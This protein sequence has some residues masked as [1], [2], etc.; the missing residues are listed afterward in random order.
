MLASNT[1][2]AAYYTV[3][4]EKPLNPR[5][6]ADVIEMGTSRQ[7][8]QMHTRLTKACF[9]LTVHNDSHGGTDPP[10]ARLLPALTLSE[11]PPPTQGLFPRDL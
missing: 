8:S 2:G 6:L 9:K 5:H 1:R 4:Q 10:R 7:L 3:G 11:R